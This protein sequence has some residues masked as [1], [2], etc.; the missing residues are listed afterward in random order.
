[1]SFWAHSLL[2]LFTLIMHLHVREWRD[3]SVCGCSSLFFFTSTLC[4]SLTLSEPV[5]WVRAGWGAGSG[6][7]GE[8]SIMFVTEWFSECRTELAQARLCSIGLFYSSVNSFKGRQTSSVKDRTICPAL[9]I[10]PLTQMT[11]SNTN[12]VQHIVFCVCHLSAKGYRAKYWLDL[13]IFEI[14][15]LK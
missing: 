5:L 3:V 13:S 10:P 12:N 8:D 9:P 11:E 1:M 14:I 6:A 4:V 15:P 7:S 2:N